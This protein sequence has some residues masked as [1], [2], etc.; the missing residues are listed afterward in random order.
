M[1]VFCF[2]SARNKNNIG[3]THYYFSRRCALIEGNQR[4]RIDKT[5]CMYLAHQTNDGTKY[6]R[7]KEGSGNGER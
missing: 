1:A 7:T 2:V 5:D 6:N 4:S 3:P